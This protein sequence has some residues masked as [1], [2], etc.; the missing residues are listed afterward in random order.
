MFTFLSILFVRI[1]NDRS[2]DREIE[3][4]AKLISVN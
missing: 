4:L 2:T 3:R 1:H